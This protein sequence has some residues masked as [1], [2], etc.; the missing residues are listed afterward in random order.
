MKEY[1]WNYITSMQGHYD[2][3]RNVDNALHD[4]KRIAN[5]RKEPVLVQAWKP[6]RGKA[7]Y[8]VK[9]KQMKHL[10]KHTIISWYKDDGYDVSYIGP[11]KY[12]LKNVHKGR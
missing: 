10:S 1:R 4:A 12:I 2:Q 5:L 9:P 8:I 6:S 11:K 7:V 3:H